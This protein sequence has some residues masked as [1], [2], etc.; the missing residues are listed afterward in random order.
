MRC[1]HESAEEDGDVVLRAQGRFPRIGIVDGEPYTFAH[2]IEQLIARARNCPLDLLTFL[3]HPLTTGIQYRHYAEI[4]NLAYL[5]VSTY[6]QWWK[7]QCRDSACRQIKK[8]TRAGIEVSETP[9]T[10]ELI[11][12]I[13]AIYN[14]MPVRQERKYP[15]YGYS[16]AR[17]RE[18]AETF[19]QRSI[20]LAARLDGKI[21]GF[22]RLVAHGSDYAAILNILALACHREKS[23]TNALIAHAV[24]VCESRGI[25]HLTYLNLTYGNKGIDGLA[26]FKM[27]HGFTRLETPRYYVP[28]TVRGMIALRLRLHHRLRDRIPIGIGN[29]LRQTRSHWYAITS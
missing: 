13:H 25:S 24:K 10:E 29:L 15:Y 3:Q 7:Q 12:A 20:Y 14:E 9:L 26:R 5:P 8:A 6:A 19:R 28:L 1:E 23:P 2:N 16:L 17:T 27:T 4:E 21:I 22:L 18:M 11:E